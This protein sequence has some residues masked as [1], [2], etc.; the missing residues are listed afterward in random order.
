MAR[1]SPPR[2]SSSFESARAGLLVSY[3]DA[4]IKHAESGFASLH[5]DQW[6]M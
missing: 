6:W 4:Q 3:Y 1:H 5:T 2:Q